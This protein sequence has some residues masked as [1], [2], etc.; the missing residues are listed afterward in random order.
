MKSDDLAENTLKQLG[1]EV[2]KLPV[3]REHGKK[4]PDFRTDWCFHCTSGKLSL[5]ST[6]LARKIGELK[7]LM[8][9][10]FMSLVTNSVE[11]RPSRALSGMVLNSWT[12]NLGWRGRLQNPV[13]PGGLH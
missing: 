13:L 5:K 1:F 6:I 3:S 10:T 8:Q 7:P 9:V 2:E 4:M 11:T 12:A